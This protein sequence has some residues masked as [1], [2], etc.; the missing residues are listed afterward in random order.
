MR[1]LCEHGRQRSRC[2]ECGGVGICEHGRERNQCKECGGAS[3]CEHGRRRHRCTDPAC[4]EQRDL[5]RQLAAQFM[6][7]AP[8][9][10]AHARR[11]AAH[12]TLPSQ[13]SSSKRPAP[14]KRAREESEDEEAEDDESDEDEDVRL[15]IAIS[16]SIMTDGARDNGRAKRRATTTDAARVQAAPAAT[17]A[18]GAAGCSSDLFTA[19]DEAEEDDLH[20]CQGQGE[21]S[22]LGLLCRFVGAARSQPDRADPGG[23]WGYTAC[24]RKPVHFDCLG[25]WLKPLVDGM[26][27][28]VDSDRGHVDLNNACCPFCKR[29]MSSSSRRMLTEEAGA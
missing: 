4:I 5:R 14:S 18:A 13:P 22:C 8:P 7:A 26:R 23:G 15:G 1:N 11:P 28:Q 27:K 17:T 2:K 16:L 12:L 9:P 20:E 29:S 24:C 25:K 19:P 10:A 6:C 21:G 3:I